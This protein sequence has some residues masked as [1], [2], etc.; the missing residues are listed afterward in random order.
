MTARAPRKA[1]AG[2]NAAAQARARLRTDLLGARSQARELLERFVL[3]LDAR[4][5]LLIRRA[6]VREGAGA[7]GT[8]EVASLARGLERLKIHPRKG[9]LREVTAVARYLKAAC[10]LDPKSE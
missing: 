8:R 9:R 5:L 1:R 6:E 2:R 4:F 10:R 7:M 3:R